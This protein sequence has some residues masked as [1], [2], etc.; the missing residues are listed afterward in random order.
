[1]ELIDIDECL[2]N[3]GGCD[4]Q[5][6]CTNTIGS[7]ECHCNQGYYGNG[8]ECSLCPE[9]YY[10]FNDTACISC[11]EDTT[12]SPGSIS[13]LDCKCNSFNHYLD[14]QT[15]TCLPC[16]YGFLLDNDS[17][18]CQSNFLSFLFF[19]LFLFIEIIQN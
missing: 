6:N 4:T 10:S 15:S 16:D 11:P 18:T 8:I 9:N 3:N 5:A 17:N 19:F 13:I 1:M 14:N 7:Y 12:S 2:E